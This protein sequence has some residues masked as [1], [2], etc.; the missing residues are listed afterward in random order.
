M[1]FEN[2]QDYF[3]IEKIEKPIIKTKKYIAKLTLASPLIEDFDQI[4][5]LGRKFKDKN[6]TDKE[7]NYKEDILNVIAE[8]KIKI[9]NKANALFQFLE[10]GNLS[11]ILGIEI[12]EHFTENQI[13]RFIGNFLSRPLFHNKQW[14]LLVKNDTHLFNVIL[15]EYKE[16]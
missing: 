13:S 5:V 11:I 4:H 9:K 16:Q 14:F 7:F 8:N 1:S 15:K 3:K 6:Y 12:N 10:I 2:Y